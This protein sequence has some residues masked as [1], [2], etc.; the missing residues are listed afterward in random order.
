VNDLFKM[1]RRFSADRSGV[2]AIILALSLT[3]VLGF[4]GL[5]VDVGLWYFD[6]RTAQDAADSAAFTAANTYYDESQSTSAVTNAKSAAQAVAATYG[7]VNGSGG[8]T[9]TVNNPPASGTHTTNS[10]AFEVVIKKSESLFFSALYLSAVSVNSRAV[11]LV[12][13]VGSGGGA[14][15][16]Q[17]LNSSSG[18]TSIGNGATVTTNVCGFAGNGTGSSSSN[19]PAFQVS[20]GAKLVTSSFNLVGGVSA[21]NGG[22]VSDSGAN[23]ANTGGAGTADPYGGVT[24]A[25]AETEA[26]AQAPTQSAGSCPNT[27]PTNYASGGSSYTLNPGFYCGGLSIANGVSVT[28]NPGVY[29]VVGGTFSLQGGTTTTATGGVTIVLTGSGSNY[30]TANIANGVNLYLNAPSTGATAGLAIFA[31]PNSPISNTSYVEGGANMD[32]NGA[33]DM[34]S[35]TVNFANGTS[36]GSACTQL[37][38]GIIQFAGGAVFSANCTGYGTKQIG[39]SSTTIAIVE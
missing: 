3:S 13:T 24:V 30:A 4:A 10:A 19:T 14:C 11:G 12:N 18:Y 28:M 37:V 15:V 1:L 34:R 17:Y 16:L 21:N 2:S 36:N 29:V 6:K 39:G 35:Q 26:A 32:V 8:V 27:T 38:G 25:A 31:D 7:Y 20:G 23:N 9:V 22:S 33:I 5:A